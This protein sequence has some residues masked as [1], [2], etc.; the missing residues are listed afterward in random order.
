MTDFFPRESLVGL[1]PTAGSARRISPLPCSKEILPVGYASKEGATQGTVKAPIQYLL[2][3]MQTAGGRNAFI[4]TNPKKIDLAAFLTDGADVGIDLAYLVTRESWGVPFTLDRAFAYVKEAIV[5]F[6]FPD[7]L[8]DQLDAFE[9]LLERL[10]EKEEELVLGAFPAN[11]PSHEDLVALDDRGRVRR[12]EIKAAKSTLTLA[13]MLAVWRPRFS[14]FIREWTDRWRQQFS[15]DRAQMAEPY[16][17]DVINAAIGAGIRVGAVTFD[18]GDYLDIGTPDSL[19][20]ATQ[21][22]ANLNPYRDC[23]I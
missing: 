22:A 16:L 19:A 12:L 4:I 7:I 5:L 21:F 6:G 18:Q 1:L 11:S 8:I 13:W 3:Q 23:L 2:E 20:R 15:G 14:G 9:T 10:H 17:G